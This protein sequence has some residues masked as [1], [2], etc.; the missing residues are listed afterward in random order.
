ME[1][2][3]KA[4]RVPFSGR[5][6]QLVKHGSDYPRLSD[7]DQFFEAKA[8]NLSTRGLACESSEPIEPLSRLFV[9]F[10]L[11]AGGGERKITCEGF[12][13]HVESLGSTYTVGISF[14]DL[15]EEDRAAIDAFVVSAA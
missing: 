13:A 9:I 4:T 7:D 8:M 14:I 5:I 15:S 10:S 1:E 12:A 3:R 2:Q 6:E 11:P